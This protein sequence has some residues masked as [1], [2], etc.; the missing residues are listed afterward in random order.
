MTSY[1][2]ALRTNQQLFVYYY[3]YKIVQTSK[4]FQ[5]VAISLR[6]YFTIRLHVSRPINY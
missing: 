5:K 3:L 4:L 6:Y 2:E 1:V